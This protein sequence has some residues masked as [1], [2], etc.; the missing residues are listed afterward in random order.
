MAARKNILIIVCDQLSQQAVGAYGNPHVNT[1]NIDALAERGVRFENAYTPLPLCRPA[2]AAY[3]TGLFPHATGVLSNGLDFSDEPVGEDIPTLGEIFSAAGYDCRHF[4]KTH[5]HGTLRGFDIEPE[6]QGQMEPVEPWS[7]N[8]DTLQDGYSVP[9]CE[10]FLRGEHDQPFLCVMDIQNP[11]NICGW[12]G[13]NQ[14]E[15]EDKPVPGELPPLPDNFEFDD[16]D[17]RPKPIQYLCCSHRRQKHAAHWNEENFRHYLAAYYHYVARGDEAVGRVM[18]ALEESGLTEDTL[19]V[20][21]AD[22]GEGMAAHRLVTKHT[23]FYEESNRIPLVFAGPGVNGAD[24]TEGRPLVS[25]LDIL[26]TLCDYARLE[27]PQVQHGRSIHGWVTG[28]Q[29]EDDREYVAG[30]WHTEWGLTVEPGRMIR[31]QR[32]K[33]TRYLE[34]DGEELFD[35]QEDPGETKNQ[36]GNPDYAEQLERHRRLLQDHIE[37]TNDPFFE[38]EWKADERWRSHPVGFEHHTG[39]STRC[40]W[41]AEQQDKKKFL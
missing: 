10:E 22:H 25:L 17:N 33:Y 2:R 3:W 40:A 20:F 24:R 7:I 4:G 5:D 35:L 1:P 29:T 41:D 23:T 39:P 12:I 27:A 13:E 38:M 16:I 34:D 19:V 15:H 14:G 31:T 8:G 32:Y 9:R 30:E 21:F 18:A 36:A 6:R 26:P 28:E 37:R 11:H